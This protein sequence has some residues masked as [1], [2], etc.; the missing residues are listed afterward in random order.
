MAKGDESVKHRKAQMCCV[1][2]FPERASHLVR[3]TWLD[4]STPEQFRMRMAVAESPAANDVLV[5]EKCIRQ[6]KRLP[7][8]KI[9]EM[10][11]S[12]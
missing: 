9:M 6:I 3:L 1:C 11:I 2:G 7:F 12:F 5:C 10:D 8:S 4:Q